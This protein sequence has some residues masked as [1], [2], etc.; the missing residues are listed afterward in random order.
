VTLK[1]P[2]AATDG[3]TWANSGSEYASTTSG[4]HYVQVDLGLN[5]GW[6]K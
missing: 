6:I 1:N 5:T 4:L 3:D 2:Q